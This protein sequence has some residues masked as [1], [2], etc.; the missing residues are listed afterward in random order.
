VTEM[1]TRE[2]QKLFDGSEGILK[3]LMAIKEV[4]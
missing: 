4:L 3:I 2:T 1:A